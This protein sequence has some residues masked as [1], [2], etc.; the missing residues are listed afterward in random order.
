MSDIVEL[1]GKV[2]SRLGREHPLYRELEYLEEDIASQRARNYERL[3][4]IMSA[5]D[6]EAASRARENHLRDQQE[7][8]KG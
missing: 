3:Q 7:L 8:S 4:R 2:K 5:I 6:P 1:I